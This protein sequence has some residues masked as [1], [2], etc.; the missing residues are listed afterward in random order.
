[1]QTALGGKWACNWPPRGAPPILIGARGTTA[2]A[3]IELGSGPEGPSAP[4]AL[5]VGPRAFLGTRRMF[6][7]FC[8][9]TNKCDSCSLK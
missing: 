5:C 3:R 8:L 9:L 6:L 4:R 2:G 7:A 1:M